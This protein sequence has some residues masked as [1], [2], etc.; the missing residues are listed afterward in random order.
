MSNQVCIK[1]SVIDA[2]KKIQELL[3]NK[4]HII[5]VNNNKGNVGHFIEKTI[6]LKLNSDCLDLADGEI[7]AFP[8]KK[9]KKSDTISPKETIAIT[10][11]DRESL[12][13]DKFENSRLYKK[14]ENVIFVPYLRNSTK[15]LIFTPILIKLS[16]NNEICN[17]I[18]KDYN[19]IQTTLNEINQIQSKIGEYIQSRTK[20][21]KNSKSRAYYFK[22]KYVKDYLISK[23]ELNDI[24]KNLITQVYSN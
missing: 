21:A 22:T 5:E 7:K 23:I 8:L 19:S 14:I 17:N 1:M 3:S 2:I 24:N 11:T 13:S 12:K 9:N 16:E 10:M 18:K 6:G 15:V 20:G 4:I